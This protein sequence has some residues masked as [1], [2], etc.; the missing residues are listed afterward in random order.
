FLNIN[1]GAS[2]NKTNGSLF[3]ISDSAFIK[4]RESA[5]LSEFGSTNTIPVQYRSIAYFTKKREDKYCYQIPVKNGNLYLVRATFSYYRFD[6]LNLANKFDLL[7]EGI[8][9]GNVDLT[10]LVDNKVRRHEIMLAPKRE[11]VSLCLAPNSET[12]SKYIFISTIELRE[13]PPSLYISTDFYTKAL[14]K[15]ARLNYGSQQEIQGYPLDP[16]DRIWS[17]DLPSGMTIISTDK[18]FGN[19]VPN[20]PPKEILQTAITTDVID[21]ITIPVDRSPIYHT[22]SWGT[23]YV[24]LYFCEI[25]QANIS[26]SDIFKVFMNNVPI[27]DWLHFDSNLQCQVVEGNLE[28]DTTDNLNLT[29]SPRAGSNMGP[30]INGLEIYKVSDV[31]NLTHPQDALAIRKIAE[32]LNVSDDWVG[33]DPCL[34]VGYS[35]TGINCSQDNPPRVIILNL[36]NMVLTGTISAD[37]AS[38]TELTQLLL[39]NN[40]LSGSIPDLSSLKNL[41]ILQLQNNQLIGDV[42][43]S[44]EELPML[45]QLFLQNNTLS[46]DVPSGLIRPGLELRFKPQRKSPADKKRHGLK[47]LIMG[48]LFG[49]FIMLI[50]IVIFAIKWRYKDRAQDKQENNEHQR[51]GP[52]LL[53]QQPCADEIENKYHRLAVEYTEE[54]IKAATNN[55]S[56]LIGR[57]GFGSVYSGRIS[58]YDVAVK[59]LCSSSNQGQREFKNEVTL[60]SRI[61]HKNLVNFIGYCRQPIV[62]LVYEYMHGGSL[63]D[64]IYGKSILPK[65][66]DWNT[67]LNIALQAAEGLLYLHQ[68]CNPPIIHRDIKSEN[69]LLDRKMTAKVAD[70]GLSKILDNSQS[71][72]LT[73]V[74]GTTGY[75]D[76]EYLG[77]SLLNEKSDVYSF[78]VVLLE[79]ISGIAPTDGIIEL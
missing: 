27:S 44:L 60:L 15:I 50:I 68:G 53:P 65:P 20:Q 62:A 22:L 3:W 43:T 56:I 63:K 10:T 59:V 6:N 33:G 12:G 79:I 51:D 34:P 16:F 47:I 7:V 5:E 2:Q 57:G 42:P 48:L 17:P 78:G 19:D 32:I 64:H 23:Y 55:Y 67:R 54:D 73:G 24:V 61:Y 30:F 21:N 26:R 18:S 35:S 14:M 11:N 39:G 46:G 4:R 69:I 36:T 31:P 45:K 71:C 9:W 77:T 41:T 72:I 49:C 1:C 66:L 28:L 70:F 52:I 13:M 29:L 76:P 25:N 37:I 40:S 75:L 58:G 38:L 8:E 74:K